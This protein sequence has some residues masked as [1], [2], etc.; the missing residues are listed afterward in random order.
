MGASHY[1][2]R[3]SAG[4]GRDWIRDVSASH[5]LDLLRRHLLKL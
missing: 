5:A 1:E 4:R 3:I 2:S